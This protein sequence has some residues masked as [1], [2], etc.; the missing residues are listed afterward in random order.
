MTPLVV[1][2]TYNER[3]NISELLDGILS[4]LPHA[5]ESRLA[6]EATLTAL[7]RWGVEGTGSE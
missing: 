7:G 5:E 4:Q 2:P 3:D 1:V 6:L